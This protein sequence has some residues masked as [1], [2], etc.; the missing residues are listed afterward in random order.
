MLPTTPDFRRSLDVAHALSGE[1]I[2]A[3][4]MNGKDI[5]FLNGYPLELIVP[6][7]FGTCWVKHFFGHRGAGQAFNRLVIGT[8]HGS[9][10]HDPCARSLKPAANLR[11]PQA[12]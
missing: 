6:G 11:R 12:A 10:A 9:L 1:P 7:Y 5:P 4:S 8:V 3:W 2:L